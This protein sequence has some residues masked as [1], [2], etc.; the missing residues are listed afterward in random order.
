MSVLGR[1]VAVAL[2]TKSNNFVFQVSYVTGAVDLRAQA[3][4]AGWDGTK[5]V[6]AVV[7]TGRIICPQTTGGWGAN[8]NSGIFVAGSFPN[9]VK[10]QIQP[11]ASVGGSGGASAVQG[12]GAQNG[13][14]GGSGGIGLYTTVAL[15]VDNRGTIA[16]GGGAGGGGAGA[17]NPDLGILQG[18]GGGNGQD[19]FYA[20]GAPSSGNMGYGGCY[21]G[22]GGGGG[23]FGAGGSNGSPSVS[24]DVWPGG[25][26][27]GTPG[28]GGNA[29]TGNSN[30]TWENTGT[31]YGA[32]A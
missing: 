24:W 14:N 20:A 27:P 10:L 23:A 29:V 28:T 2:S 26:S 25:Y 31:R 6:V 3:L 15:T 12:V 4:S 8:G 16:G 5:K 17:L 1:A 32:V 11:G 21:G 19:F 13:G 9:G 22:D 7:P 18:G 30:I